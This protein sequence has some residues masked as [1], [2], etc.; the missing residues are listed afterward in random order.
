MLPTLTPPNIKK[1][2]CLKC[3][4]RFEEEIVDEL[5][6][7]VFCLRCSSEEILPFAE[8]A[9]GQEGCG[10]SHCP[11]KIENGGDIKDCGAC[12]GCHHGGDRT[13]N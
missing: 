1:F 12:N 13:S 5:N 2:F 10:S 6:Q 7:E 11:R 4:A 8:S 3:E 9:I